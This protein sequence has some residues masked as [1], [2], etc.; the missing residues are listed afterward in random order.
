MKLG[1]SVLPN[2]NRDST[3]RNRTSPFAFTGNKFE[4]RMLGSSNSIACANI[5]LNAAV[6]ESLRVYADRLEAAG[7]GDFEEALHQ[8]IKK[9]FKDH[10]RIIF[11]GNGYDDNWIKEATEV[12]GLLNLRTT[13][14]ALPRLL[15]KKNIDLLTSQG[16]YSVAEIKSR[17]EITLDNYCKLVNIEALTMVDMA[18]RDILPAI[19][20]YVKDLAETCQAK[21]AVL[22]E[23]AC[24][25]EKGQLARLC[26][27]V[28]EI[29]SA[30]IKLEAA[31]VKYR[32]IEDVTERSEEIRDVILPKMAELRIVCDESE[33]LTAAKYW[34]FPTYEK[35]LFS[36]K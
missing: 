16:I 14:D 28:D 11:N 24:Q 23:N 8:L 4:F 7:A 32:T 34:P 20:S 1:A 10:R 13:P 36:V 33:I 26:R 6:A 17:Y 18:R 19:D 5:M 3:D 31:L 25:Y 22:S 27:L 15:D 12:R 21:M 2:F 30:T 9:T 29:D 35:L